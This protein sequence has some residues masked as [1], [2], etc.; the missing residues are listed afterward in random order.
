MGAPDQLAKD[1][2][3]EEV[4]RLFG[5]RVVWEVGPELSLSEV[6]L[7]GVLEPL[8][9]PALPA[10]WCFLGERVT[11]VEVKMPGDHLDWIALQR[12]LLR[13]QA[14]QVALMER[15]PAYDKLV[16]LWMVAPHVPRGIQERYRPEAV[17]PGC[18]RLAAGEFEV[19]WVAAN[20]LPLDGAL[21]PFL[22]ARSGRALVGMLQWSLGR[23][24]PEWVD[25]VLEVVNLSEEIKTMLKRGLRSDGQTRSPE[26]HRNLV[27]NLEAMVEAWAPELQAK[28]E[29]RGARQAMRAGEVKAI[30]TACELLGIELTEARR[31]Q[32][33]GLDLAGLR[34][35]LADLKA[36]RAW[37]G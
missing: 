12:A 34:G 14:L 17:A 32:I 9:L 3:A 37:P 4:P 35:L 2:F 5:H 10:P 18:W 26:G 6:R 13:R 22:V 27:A 31:G 23:Q 25:R 20:E 28:L 36:R 11:V 33:A 8:D 16:G 24:P 29:D 1:I 15:Q 21:L 30:E 7:D 19:L